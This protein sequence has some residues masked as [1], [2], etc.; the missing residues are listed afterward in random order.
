VQRRNCFDR[1]RSKVYPRFQLQLVLPPAN[2]AAQG[3]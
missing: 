2:G 1:E 3:F